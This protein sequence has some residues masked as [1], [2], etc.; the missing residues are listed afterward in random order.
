MPGFFYL[1]LRGTKQSR[2][3]QIQYA[4]DEVSTLSL[5]DKI[6]RQYVLPTLIV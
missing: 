2:S 6:E 5:N 3:M 1:S 4:Y